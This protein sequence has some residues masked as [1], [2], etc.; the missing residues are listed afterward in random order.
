MVATVELPRDITVTRIIPKRRAA[1]ESQ[2]EA[3]SGPSQTSKS[4]CRVRF[5]SNNSSSAV[6]V[7]VALIPQKEA[8]DLS[9]LYYTRDE[10]KKMISKA[11]HY[12]GH[13][14]R[15]KSHVGKNMDKLYESGSS[16]SFLHSSSSSSSL[17]DHSSSSSSLSSMTEIPESLE[18][19]YHCS[20]RGLEPLLSDNQAGY[21]DKAIQKVLQA[22]KMHSTKD[23]NQRAALICMRSTLMTRK[24]RIFA[25]RI[26]TAD[27]LQVQLL[28]Y[29]IWVM[30][31]VST[32]SRL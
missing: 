10:I 6:N 13:L 1:V 29:K 17:D 14:Y 19:L 20:A 27:A 11:K 8:L 23:A 9:D 32:S 22:Q 16:S 28:N 26:G 5:S 25:E 31:R 21:R 2:H 3:Y 12:A 15:E 4:R 18:G 30:H 24:A 7:K